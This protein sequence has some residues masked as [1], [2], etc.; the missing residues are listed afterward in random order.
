LIIICADLSQGAIDE[1]LACLQ[2]SDYVLD[3]PGLPLTV[4]DRCNGSGCYRC[5]AV[6][7]CDECGTHRELRIGLFDEG[8]TTCRACQNKK[9]RKR[10]A[11]ND[12]V[13]EVTLPTTET[14]IDLDEYLNETECAI[15]E[16]VA[17][18]VKQHK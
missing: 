2:P 9:A 18:A 14:D 7:R 16:V 10:S 15:T 6:Q 5:E 3:E 8:S 13:H 11:L 4:C 17:D 1:L 12:A